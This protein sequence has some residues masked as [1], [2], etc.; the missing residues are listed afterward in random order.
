MT[1]Q[2]RSRVLEIV[3]EEVN[4]RLPV[5]G[6]SG[7]AGTR[8]AVE[9][10]KTAKSI[11]C[12]GAQIIL[13][14]YHKPDE[15]GMFAHYKA[16]SEAVGPDFGLQVYNNPGVSGCWIKPH[17]MQRIAK[18]GNVVSDKDN[19]GNP[20]RFLDM[21]RAID[22][23]QMAVVTGLGERFYTMVA[24]FGCRGFISVSAN[25]APEIA[26][27]VYQAGVRGDLAAMEEAMKPMA[28]M[29]RYSGQVAAAHAPSTAVEGGG[30]MVW[31]ALVKA[32]MTHRGLAG[33]YARLPMSSL[34][35]EEH[36]GVA[37]VIKEMG[38]KKVS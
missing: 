9:L 11:G 34:T 20:L 23:D 17:L 13:P 4:G 26:W 37:A 27:A 2:E 36:A 22:Q 29:G 30:A 19:Q 8:L 16:L 35:P 10:T 12:D 38:L 18:L 6:G 5:L 1:D 31:L 25:Y 32:A 21:L 14:Y 15:D 3:V 33:G 28:A 24:Q 7:S